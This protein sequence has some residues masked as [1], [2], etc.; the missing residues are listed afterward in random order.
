VGPP[1]VNADTDSEAYAPAPPHAPLH[2]GREAKPAPPGRRLGLAGH[3]RTVER[4]LVAVGVSA[5]LCL[6][7]AHFVEPTLKGPIDIIGPPPFKSFN[8]LTMFWHYRLVVYVFPLFAIVGYALLARF[9][10]LRS[11]NP[12][13]GKRTIELVEPVSAVQPTPDRASWGIPARVLLPAAV[14]VTAC[15]AR[16]GHTDLLAVAAGVVYVVL[17]AVVAEVWARR[18]DGQ[19][20]RALAAVNGVGGAVAAV[21]GLWFVSAHTV[22]QTFT[23]TRTFPWLVWWLP[24]LGVV[25][26][27]WWSARQLR[28]GRGA[29]DVELTL[30]TV[31]VGAIAVFLALSVFPEPITKFNGFDDAMDMASSSLVARGYFPWRDLLMGHGLFDDVIT[32][33]LGRAIFGDTIWGIFAIHTVIVVPLFWVSVYLFA[34]W[35]SRRNPWFLALGFLGVAYGLRPLEGWAKTMG[36][37][38]GVL[39]MW[40]EKFLGLPIALIVLGET[41]RRRS[42]VWAAGLTLGLFAQVILVSETI[43]F[44]PPVLACVVAADLV[45]RRPER[46]LWAN[47]R[48]TRWCVGTGL[49]AMAVWAAFL[50]SFG[51]LRG[52]IEPYVLFW[53][54]FELTTAKPPFLWALPWVEGP[55]FAV[56]IACVLLTIWQVAIKVATR[57][58]WEARDWVA[59]AA[60]VFVAVFAQKAIG[61]FDS[62]HVWQ[63]FEAGASLVVLWAWRLLDGL[64][65]LL[66]AW[67]RGWGARPVRLVRLAQPVTAVLVPAIALGLVFSGPLR[68]IDGQH[69]LSGVTEARFPK[70]GYVANAAIDTDLLRDLD[71]AIRAYAGDD[72]PV[73]DMT[74]SLGYYYYLLGRVPGT[75][76]TTVSAGTSERAQHVIIDALKAVRPPVVIFEATTTGYPTSDGI[77]NQVRHYAVSDYLLHG[78]TPVLLTHGVLVMARN[79]LA[80]SRP[81]PTLSTRP[82]TTDL[83]FTGAPCDWGAIP[84]YLPVP[85]SARSTTLPVR[86]LGARTIVHYTGWGTDPTTHRAA[87]TVLIAEND[88]V[89][90]T[91]TPSIDRPDV[92]FGLHQPESV[93]GFRY[94]AVLDG[95]LPSTAYAVGA[96][97]V[98][99]PLKRSPVAPVAFL[100]MPDGSQVRVEPTMAGYLEDHQVNVIP[101]VGEIQLPSGINLRDYNLATVSSGTDLSDYRIESLS[102]T[103][104]L[105]GGNVALTDQILDNPSDESPRWHE[106]LAT[107]QYPSSGPHLTLRVGS[108]P[109]WYGYDPSKPLYVLQSGGPPVTSVT[110][111]AARG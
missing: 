64:G 107:W 4:F 28:A 101:S 71:T 81:V 79:D 47:L 39:L 78:W 30:L 25:A 22:V 1:Q 68:T 50:A 103:D 11:R 42:A 51:A 109:Q 67:W 102:W 61:C 74:Y 85:D 8:Y 80:A 40:S 6:L 26:I 90:A 2:N 10:P 7:L 23:G 44:V 72:G 56:C 108:C 34:V 48:L 37:A 76:F 106:I 17:V 96:D 92:A 82:L 91:V 32:G 41:L 86:T 46:S 35:V 49:A 31:V 94:D 59:V 88:R 5:V 62:V 54:G 95:I 97:G 45:H 83:Y 21:L 12:R 105:G 77:I 20:W 63:V 99:H 89:V 65:R 98:A 60:A 57:A 19:R 27:V 55:M 110:L 9:G 66:A 52:F 69:R 70:I 87:S 14:V 33:D 58:D 104:G 111:S 53:P 13:P 93:S 15:G 29:R 38:P 43:A 36:E 18:T 84:N 3:R 73:F 16:T 100:R 24:V 75:R